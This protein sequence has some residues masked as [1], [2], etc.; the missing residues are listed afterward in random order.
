MRNLAP[1]EAHTTFV[2]LVATAFGGLLL[3]VLIASFGVFDGDVQMRGGAVGF[4]IVVGYLAALVGSAYHVLLSRLSLR[5]GVFRIT[6]FRTTEVDIADA[7]QF[8]VRRNGAVI[9]RYELRLKDGRAVS[10]WALTVVGAESFGFAKGRNR[11]R[12]LNRFIAE[13]QAT[14]SGPRSQ[15]AET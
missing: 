6:N 3:F 15:E 14:A 8:A 11:V 13:S 10:V 9:E 4:V 12:S 1:R 5:N 7:D 2:G